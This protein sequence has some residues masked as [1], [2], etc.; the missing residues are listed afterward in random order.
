MLYCFHPQVSLF[1]VIFTIF[2]LLW[3]ECLGVKVSF[4]ISGVVGAVPFWVSIDLY[5]VLPG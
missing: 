2:S 1:E 3:A 4:A 5:S